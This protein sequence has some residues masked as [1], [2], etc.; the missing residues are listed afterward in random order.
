MASLDTSEEG[1]PNLSRIGAEVVWI[2]IV[3]PHLLTALISWSLLSYEAQLE[4]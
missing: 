4:A 1:A 3:L 2:G